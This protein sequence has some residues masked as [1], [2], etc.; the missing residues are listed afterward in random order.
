MPGSRE[1]APSHRKCT[2]EKL[3]TAEDVLKKLE[4]MGPHSGRTGPLGAHSAYAAAPTTAALAQLS[5]L[6][7]QGSVEGGGGSAAVMQHGSVGVPVSQSLER[8]TPKKSGGIMG[9]LF[10]GK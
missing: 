9:K 3:H 6:Q 8:G 4:R 7:A 2:Q 1:C 10:S 5:R